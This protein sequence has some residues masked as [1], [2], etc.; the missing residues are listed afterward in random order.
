MLTYEQRSSPPADDASALIAHQDRVMTLEDPMPL[1]RTARRTAGR[2]T[3]AAERAA[4]SR[5]VDWIARAGLTAR[6]VVYILI[7][8]L[9]LLVAG[10]ASAQVDQKGAL[11]QVLAEPF[12]TWIVGALAVGF[13]GYALWRF[14]ESA[15]GVTGE[16]HKT[17]PRLQALARGLIYAF[18]AYT[19]V[20]L[21]RGST[22]TQ[23]VQ[24]QGYAAAAMAQP[25]GRWAVGLAGLG[26]AVAGT[27]M[28]VGG[29]RLTFM[30]YFPAAGLAPRARA[31]IRSLGRIGTIARGLVF[32]LM[33]ALVVA[34]AWT[35]DAAKASGL[36]GA[37]KTLRDRPFGGALVG[38]A[39][40]GLIV[41]GVYGLAE[42]RY[43][44]V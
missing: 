40:V 34:A 33:G 44:R 30:R 10:G 9:A 37:L 42:A 11:A 24:Q 23:S 3:G 26:I 7:G 28:V 6:G 27:T 39:A 16:G 4:G 22:G 31:W 21:L 20:S 43:R 19:A 1:F 18:L 2:A 14:S 13:A 41:F 8:V 25:G 36:D 5:P 15:F 29:A 35:Y 38:V 17:G 32:T 12:G